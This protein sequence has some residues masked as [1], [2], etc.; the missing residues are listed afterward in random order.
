MPQKTL[1]IINP[2]SGTR[3]RHGLPEAIRTAFCDTADIV[4]TEYAGHATELARQG[5]FSGYGRVVAIGGDGTIN[6]TATG[7]LDTGVTLAI[8]PFGSGNGLA[9]HLHIPMHRDEALRVAA[10][11]KP[12][13][14]D[15][16]MVS[17][18]PFFCTMGVGFDA[19]VSSEFAQC[20]RRGLLSYS[21]IAVSNFLHYAPQVYTIEVDGNL[22]NYKA[23]IVAVCNASQYGNNAFIAP[24]ASMADGKLD[25]TVVER[26]GLGSL[27][28]AG[29]RLFTHR[30][31]RSRIVHCLR[32]SR[33][34][35]FRSEPG[36]GHIDGEAVTLPAELDI[37]CRSRCLSVIIP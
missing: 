27:A 8:V 28:T 15:C 36:P 9:R 18:R 19:Q 5:A 25:V 16:G 33:V 22:C 32:G 1:V 11:G 12:F 30:L 23:F 7:L 21:R 29:V 37:Y 3:S 35:I 20:K 4:Y 2:K 34:R 6:E 14:V 31:D 13:A 24:H 26:G 17:G 10:H